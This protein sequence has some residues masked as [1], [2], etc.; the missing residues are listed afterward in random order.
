MQYATEK[1]KR[2]E[3]GGPAGVTRNT[4]HEYDM[5]LD[6]ALELGRQHKTIA[7]Y[8]VPKMYEILVRKEGL[9]P[10]DAASKIYQDLVG[11]W[12]KD[13]IRRLL[14]QETKDQAAR[15]RQALSRLH[16]GRGAGL[17][18]RQ[19]NAGTNDVVEK[20]K[21]ENERLEKEVEELARV[22]NF[23]MERILQLERA[24]SMQ[25]HD[26][27][28]QEESRAVRIETKK[29]VVLPP[30]LFVKTYMLLKGSSKPLVLKIVNNEVQ[31]IEKSG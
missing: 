19:D 9:E 5:L 29:T 15:E 17:V 23:H 25:Q 20:L 12:Q 27:Q 18:L 3:K 14:P 6:E 16:M 10:R 22:K 31:D 21:K 7:K 11:V 4:K 13:T 1:I 28:R 2:T 26:K 8:Y 30:S 24:L